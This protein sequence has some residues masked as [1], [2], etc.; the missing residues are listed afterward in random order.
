MIDRCDAFRSL[1]AICEPDVRSGMFN[2]MT[3]EGW[4]PIS[5]EDHHEVI[6][7]IALHEEVPEKIATQFETARNVFLCSWFVYRFGPVAQSQALSALE[8]ALRTRLAE[9]PRKPAQWTPPLSQLLDM[10]I[11]RGIV[12]AEGMSH[13]RY[14]AETR[15]R[16]RHLSESVGR[17]DSGAD[18]VDLDDEEIQVQPHDFDPE[19][20]ARMKSA[21]R[22]SRNDKAHGS[23]N[24]DM[25]AAGVLR[26]V[27]DIVNQLYSQREL[28]GGTAMPGENEEDGDDNQ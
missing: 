9:I 11:S 10:A 28:E 6:V 25:E 1:D 17:G 7:S 22:F 12:C 19:F 26:A 18:A 14:Q 15:A 23:T 20:F 5:L 27:A 13:A 3:P 24:L 4:R 21:L 8:L 16:R 2:V